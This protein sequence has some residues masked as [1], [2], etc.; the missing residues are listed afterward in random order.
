[1][2]KKQPSTFFFCKDPVS[3]RLGFPGWE[4]ENKP[5]LWPLEKEQRAD[6]EVVHNQK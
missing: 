2:A 1:M 5:E 6:E 4:M 3:M